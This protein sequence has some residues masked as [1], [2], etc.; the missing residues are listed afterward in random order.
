MLKVKSILALLFSLL[1]LSTGVGAALYQHFHENN[2]QEVEKN[3]EVVVYENQLKYD[4]KPLSVS[5]ED[6]ETID[7]KEKTSQVQAEKKEKSESHSVLK[8]SSSFVTLFYVL[9]SYLFSGPFDSQTF[10]Y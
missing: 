5:K 10:S 7:E 6:V 1:V 2:L 4:K 3:D 9:V 8:T